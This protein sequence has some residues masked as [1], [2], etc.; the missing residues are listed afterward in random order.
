MMIYYKNFYYV[1]KFQKFIFDKSVNR[2]NYTLSKKVYLNGK[3][4]NINKIWN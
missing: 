4:I 2:K 1:Q 3:Y